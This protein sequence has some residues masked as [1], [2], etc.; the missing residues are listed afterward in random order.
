M[1]VQRVKYGSVLLHNANTVINAFLMCGLLR[2]KPDQICENY[3]GHAR[4]YLQFKHS[5][6]RK[7]NLLKMDNLISFIADVMRKIN[8]YSTKKYCNF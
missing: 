2:L 7:K 5:T 8:V 4:I 1:S 6:T 3:S